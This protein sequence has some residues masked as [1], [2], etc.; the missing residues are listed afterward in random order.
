MSESVNETSPEEIMERLMGAVMSG[1][2]QRLLSSDLSTWDFADLTITSLEDYLTDLNLYG[3]TSVDLLAS[4][5]YEASGDLWMDENEF[6]RL[7]SKLTPE[8]KKAFLKNLIHEIAT[9]GLE[10][11]LGTVGGDLSLKDVEAY[12]NGKK[13][14]RDLMDKLAKKLHVDEEESYYSEG[15]GFW[16]GAFLADYLTDEEVKELVKK[17]V[18]P[19]LEKHK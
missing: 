17:Y 11:F 8:Q 12:L 10:E 14:F 7:W 9:Y 5:A 3:E 4:L 16:S 2:A 15:E 18:L 13:S 19:Q 6:K 1:W